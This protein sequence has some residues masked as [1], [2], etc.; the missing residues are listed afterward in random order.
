M[1][2]DF[3]LPLVN[4]HCHAAMVAFRGKGEG[5]P[6]HSWLNDCIWPLEAE[7]VN[8]EFVYE[9]TKVAIKEM[10][11]N[12]IR[13]FMDMYFH[14]EEVAKAAEE[15]GMYVVIG[16]GLIDLKGNDVFDKD[17]GETERLLDKYRDS[18]FVDVSVAPHSPYTVNESNLIKSKR[19][20]DKYGAIYHMHVAETK[21]EYD[22]SIKERGLSPIGYLDRIGV[23]DSKTVLA[24]CVWLS[25]GDIEIL[26][27]RKCSVSHCP[28][29]NLKLGSGISPISE[30]L[31][32]GVNVSIGTDGAASSNRLDVWEAGKFASL[33]QKG[34]NYDPTLITSKDVIRMMTINGIVALGLEGKKGFDLE[35]MEKE[36]EVGNYDYLF[37]LQSGELFKY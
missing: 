1:E 27:R 35:E 13:A 22:D 4:S 12:G 34:I 18:E 29:S 25:G 28:L 31:E 32:A 23:L 24:H 33:L 6:L 9:Q 15:L 19:L 14:E 8:P 21:K 2:K 20:A 5:L 11:G 16:E 3:K 37:H 26:A 36:I 17:L 7:N 10:Q 30:L